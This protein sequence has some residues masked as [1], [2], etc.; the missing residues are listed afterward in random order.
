[1]KYLII[2]FMVWSFNSKADFYDYEQDGWEELYEQDGWELIPTGV[3]TTP[4]ACGAALFFLVTIS[5]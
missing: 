2:V 3:V 5:F 1:M 4:A